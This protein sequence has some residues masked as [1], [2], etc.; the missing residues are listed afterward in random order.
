METPKKTYHRIN[1]EELQCLHV[2]TFKTHLLFSAF[3]EKLVLNRIQWEKFQATI[4][5][6]ILGFKR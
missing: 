6:S 1:L 2:I 3:I 4:Q 5:N